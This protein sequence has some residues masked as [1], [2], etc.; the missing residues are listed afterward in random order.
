MRDGSEPIEFRLLDLHLNRLEPGE[1]LQV[2]ESI[3]ASA[4]LAAQSRALRD[5]LSMLDRDEAP[6]TPGDLV[7]SVMARVEAEPRVIP[8]PQ[9][10]AGAGA[11]RS[12]QEISATPVL[13]LRELVAIAACITLFIG[14]FV[15]GYFKAQNIARRNF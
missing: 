13:S 10:A 12:G 11:L 2:E 15:P 9:K 1:A 14:V 4:E 7:E 3:A 8:F 5:V 6:E